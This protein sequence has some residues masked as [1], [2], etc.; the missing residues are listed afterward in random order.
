MDTLTYGMQVPETGD[1]GS[2]WFPAL[3]DNF[4]QLDA[5]THNGTDSP[6][7]TAAS[8]VVVTQSVASG[9]W[10]ATSNGTYRQ[11]ITLPA[12][13]ASYNYIKPSFKGSD[14]D[15]YHLKTEY[16]S[17]STYYVYINDNS[18]TLTAVYTS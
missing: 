16:V 6:R 3:E 7:I 13:I 5:H 14:G 11:L 1:L 15:Y 9:S 2:S 4:T 8:S 10:S 12:A 18:L 17:A